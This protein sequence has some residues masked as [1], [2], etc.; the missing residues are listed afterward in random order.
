MLYAETLA[1]HA[2]SDTTP[3]DGAHPEII[4]GQ[5]PA[6]CIAAFRKALSEYANDPSSPG[7]LPRVV[8][9][10]RAAAEAISRTPIRAKEDGFSLDARRLVAEVSKSGV[11]DLPGDA[12]D[13]EF[14][15]GL[16]PG[17]WPQLL[18]AMVLTSS[19][20]WSKTP[21]LG[22]VPEWM[23]G[24]YAAWLF[25]PPQGF[26]AVGQA[27]QYAGHYQ[28]HAEEL[29]GWVRRNRGS[30]AV[31]SAM[32]A[33]AETASSIPLYFHEGNLRAHALL[34]GKL[35][36]AAY[37]RSSDGL[38]PF[39]QSR[40]DRR[41]RV[42]F[43][44]RHF[45]P[46]TE[47]YTTLP[48]FEQL[49][50]GSFEVL[51]FAIHENPGPLENYACSR[52]S[53]FQVLPG[54]LEDQLTV[55][56]S[57]NLD[58]VVFGTNVTAVVNEVA[59]LALHR[60][61]PLQAVNNS[62]CITTGLPEIDLYISGSFTEAAGAA[63]QYSERLGLLP[64]PAHA[65]NYRQDCRE[66]SGPVSRASLGLPE[67]A[68]V[69][70]TAANYFKII[71]EMQ[72]AWARL[73]AAVPGSYL[74]VHPFNPNWSS[75]Y[76]IA[77][78]CTEF[79]R[80]LEENGV[81]SSR[82]IVSSTRYPSRSDVKELLKVG[83]L[84]L[85]TY[86]FGGVN[87]LADPLELG[88]PVVAWE[89]DSFRSRMGSALLRELNIPGLIATSA[90]E[91]HA[92]ALRLATDAAFRGETALAISGAMRADPLFFDTLAASDAFGRL[93]ETAYDELAENGAEAF[94]SGPPI[95]PRAAEREGKSL[96]RA[97]LDLSA[98]MN[99]SAAENARDVL[100]LHPNHPSARR[101]LGR[102]LL[103]DG[104]VDRGTEYLIAAVQH[105]HDDA[106]L[107]LEL[108]VG[109]RRQGQM[110]ESLQALER[111]IRLDPRRLDA[112]I[113]FHEVARN[114][115]AEELA[116]EALG[117]ARTLGPEDPRVIA[118]SRPPGA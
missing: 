88:L 13:L 51:L 15:G 80:V 34:R 18:A 84:Y 78:F 21:L 14:L 4:P 79:D 114:S 25:H 57:A 58:V 63:S 20:T 112:W 17:S 48:T 70:V 45:G 60:I 35:L 43:I 113:M 90:A 65:F 8:E 101:L 6:E 91:Y 106:E 110:A 72:A 74:L 105:F 82:L 98:G 26:T 46:Q 53:Q 32:T 16:N 44:N 5:S 67:D 111:S 96:E 36:T 49:D 69:F 87:S 94:R 56:R 93:L 92:T 89:G 50:P 30:A 59:L 19:W 62:S 3:S 37:R 116:R 52:C 24:D 2:A 55:L 40:A 7:V 85:D 42:G 61:A 108:A 99:S 64:G 81:D 12:A 22:R 100:A 31:R 73:L 47:T 28:R 23:W 75:Q 11:N 39:A 27:S 104:I 102:A 66:P 33:F 118:L 109:L 1:T 9:T 68:V 10:R 95:H 77:R 103:A 38:A 115:G 97:A 41:L 83:T 86:P 71:P 107:W 54:S 29:H 117:V 76:P